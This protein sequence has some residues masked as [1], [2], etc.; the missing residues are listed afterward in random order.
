MRNRASIAGIV[1]AAAAAV[2]IPALALATET[3]TYSYDAKGRLV[4]VVH[5]GDVNNGVAVEYKHDKADNRTKVK[6][7]GSANPPPPPP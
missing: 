4:K 2:A 6:V 1:L 5:S 7:T 3:V